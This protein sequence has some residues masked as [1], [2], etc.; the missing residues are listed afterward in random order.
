MLAGVLFGIFLPGKV[1]WIAWTGDIFLKLLRMIVMPFI[2]ISIVDGVVRA[3]SMQQLSRLGG[4]AVLYYLSTTMLAVLTSLVLVNWIRPGAG[5]KIFGE[6]ILGAGS[7]A[8]FF[9]FIPANIFQAFFYGNTLQLIFVALFFGA[10]LVMV[11]DKVPTLVAALKEANEFFLKLTTV[12]IRLAPLG[13]FGLLAVMVQHMDWPTFVGI[14]KFAAVILIGLVIHGGISLPLIFKAF[15]NRPFLP[16]VKAMQPALLTAFSTSS[17]SAT[18]PVTIECVE[19][20]ARVAPEIAGFV[21]PVGA[22]VNM[23]GTAIYEAAACLFVAQS[24]GVELNLLQQ[25]VVFFTA[26]LAAIG[27]AAIPSAGLVTLAMVLTAVNL[28]LE[29]IG[30]LLAIDRPLDMSRTVVNVWGDMVGCAVVE[31]KKNLRTKK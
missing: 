15:S 18:L 5:V 22:T 1:P 17:S 31:G 29:G 27:A 4:K 24:L 10:G 26:T 25:I 8:S 13:V 28:P 12:I 2:F 7:T 20:E 16:Y 9:D 19:K 11:I 21:L 3:G 30:F 6:K 23:D 14:G